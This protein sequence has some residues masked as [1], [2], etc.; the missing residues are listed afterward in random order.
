MLVTGCLFA[1]AVLAEQGETKVDFHSL[2]PAVQHAAEQQS[3]GATVR[4]YSKEIEDGKPHYEVELSINGKTKDLL[5]DPNGAVVEVEQQV[6]YDTL[7][8]TVK[9][10]LMKQAGQGKILK[11]ESVTN[12]SKVTYEAVVSTRGKKRE[13]AVDRDGAPRK[14]D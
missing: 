3:K 11:V 4:G 10:G 2:P 1:W 5:L 12:G 8:G 9:T 13:I 7:S 6:D 14:A